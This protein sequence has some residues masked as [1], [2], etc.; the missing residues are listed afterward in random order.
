MQR[1]SPAIVSALRGYRRG[2]FLADLGAGLTVG[3]IALPLG[4]VWYVRN[5]LLGH[6]A[7][8]FPD[9]YWQ[10]LAARSG[11]EFGWPLLAL[12]GRFEDRMVARELHVALV[13]T[14]IEQ[15]SPTRSQHGR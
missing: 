13:L 5:V 9:A 14:K 4:S 10:T 12:V 7:I 1:F 15:P 8:I 11:V 6:L 3:L 2:D